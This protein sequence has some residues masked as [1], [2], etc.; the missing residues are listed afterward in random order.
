MNTT[1]TAN[2]DF[3]KKENKEWFFMRAILMARRAA[4]KNAKVY[5]LNQAAS[6]GSSLSGPTARFIIAQLAGLGYEIRISCGLKARV[7]MSGIMTRAFSPHGF[8][9]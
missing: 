2:A 6:F 8:S 7:I 9:P 4:G 5:A 3:V 1:A